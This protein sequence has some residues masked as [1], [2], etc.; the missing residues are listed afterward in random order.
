MKPEQ[1]SVLRKA[2]ELWG[3][4]FQ[5]DVLIE[6]CSELIMAIVQCR[7]GRCTHREIVEELA[8]VYVAGYQLAMMLGMPEVLSVANEKI[9]RLQKRV[10]ADDPNLGKN[11]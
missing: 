6:E 10:E 7:R 8:D 1:E 5:R 2:I 9:E 4:E 11:K 3:E